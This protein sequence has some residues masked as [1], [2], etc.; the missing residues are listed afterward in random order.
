M[1]KKFVFKD[2]AFDLIRYWAAITVM[3][4]HFT[5]KATAYVQGDMVL[6]VIGI[7]STFFPGVVVLFSMSGFLISA[8]FER[9]KDKKEF[10]TKRVL[11]MYPELW[12][13]TI[14]IWWWYVFLLINFWIKVFWYG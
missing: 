14:V 13:C 3:L 7:V 2:N 6:N 8:S 9:S 11:R 5:W 1:E 12:V 4:G 10:F